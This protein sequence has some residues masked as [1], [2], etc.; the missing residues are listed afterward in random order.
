[1]KRTQDYYPLNPLAEL[2]Y[3]ILD[4]SVLRTTAALPGLLLESKILF[5]EHGFPW[6]ERLDELH[7]SL[8]DNKR[9]AQLSDAVLPE[10]RFDLEELYGLLLVGSAPDVIDTGRLEQLKLSTNEKAI[11]CAIGNGKLTGKQIS[12]KIDKYTDNGGLRT[13]LSH[14][15]KRGVLGNRSPG[16]FVQDQFKGLIAVMNYD[17]DD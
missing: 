7:K 17:G 5:E 16:Y 15:V 4:G 9:D 14:L 6:P 10:Y 2:L 12:K 3:R 11:L 1:M 13:T 8:R